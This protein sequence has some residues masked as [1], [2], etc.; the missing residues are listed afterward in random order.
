MQTRSS[1]IRWHRLA[2]AATTLVLTACVPNPGTP[3]TPPSPG[4]T[5]YGVPSPGP[6][7]SPSPSPTATP[8]PAPKRYF[9]DFERETLGTES[10]DFI[11]IT[12]E[13]V[14]V[15]W[16]YPGNWT[17]SR[18]E[19]GN[20][21]FY[22]DEIR[23]QPNVSFRRYKGTALGAENG[24][25]PGKYYSEVLM[26]PIRSPNNYSPTGDQGVQFYY[27][28]YNT[29]LEVIVKPTELEIWEANQAAPQTTKGWKRLWS[30]PL[31]T[32]GGDKR[33]IG[34]LV[35]VAAKEFTAYLD[36]KPL[37]TV[38]SELLKPQPAYVTLRA[39]GNVV[40]FDEVLIEER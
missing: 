9:N 37:K 38:T 8:T 10:S 2:L 36:G 34:A 27:L 35:D 21:V 15:P 1:Q 33:R 28:N 29:Y 25:M 20:K 32:E 24:K 5:Q 17:I 6:S 7:A 22:H 23:T 18:D 40:N 39:I 26:R 13:G 31:K 12:R 16:I 11:D 19:A 4:P 3:G 14:D 30:T